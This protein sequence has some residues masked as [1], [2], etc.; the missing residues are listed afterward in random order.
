MVVLMVLQNYM[1][2]DIT[3][4]FNFISNDDWFEERDGIEFEIIHDN[5]LGNYQNLSLENMEKLDY[6]KE[7]NKKNI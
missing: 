6:N 2:Y 1:R 7:K 3:E 5:G 4:D